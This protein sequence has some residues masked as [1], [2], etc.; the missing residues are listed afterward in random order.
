M[1]I[2][3][4]ILSTAALA[5]LTGCGSLNPFND[6]RM[7]K[8][9]R[10]DPEDRL[11][12]P[13]YMLEAQG[14]NIGVGEGR[15]DNPQTSRDLAAHFAKVELCSKLSV[16]ANSLTRTTA[17]QNSKGGRSATAVTGTVASETR[18]A[19]VVGSPDVL[20]ISTVQVG[21]EYVTWT[22]I[23]SDSV[24]QPQTNEFSAADQTTA[25]QLRTN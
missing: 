6:S 19:A 15:A 3:K 11:R 13:K 2:G 1:T 9:D 18:C 10:M 24:E 5:I 4:L 14:S 8:M 25:N 7:V 12:L 16:Q 20:D 22:R 17:T 23:Q 21:R